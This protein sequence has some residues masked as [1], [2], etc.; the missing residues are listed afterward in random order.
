MQRRPYD[1]RYGHP[2]E[3]GAKRPLTSCGLHISRRTSLPLLRPER[4]HSQADRPPT[5]PPAKNKTTRSSLVC[6]LC[7]AHSERD[8]VQVCPAAGGVAAR[9]EKGAAAPIVVRARPTPTY[10]KPRVA[11]VVSAPSAQSASYG[12]R[13]LPAVP[14]RGCDATAKKSLRT[15]QPTD[16]ASSV[17][18]SRDQDPR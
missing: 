3:R 6:V 1:P 9:L 14:S 13:A 8:D 11:Q 5:Y 15:R 18:L 12:H 2:R 16:L 17:E 4:W 7:R 10:Y